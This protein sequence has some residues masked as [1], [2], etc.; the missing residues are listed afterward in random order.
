MPL[1][2]NKT[3]YASAQAEIAMEL[4]TGTVLSENNA[5]AKL[6]MASTT[7]IMTAILVL[8]QGNLDDMVTVSTRAANSPEHAILLTFCCIK[9]L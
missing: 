1:S 9:A 3:A 2:V 8:E 6:P 7:K 5:D 4:T